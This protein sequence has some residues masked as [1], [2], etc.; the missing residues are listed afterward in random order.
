[1]HGSG[2]VLQKLMVAWENANHSGDNYAMTV[3]AAKLLPLIT[4]GEVI[5][6][7]ALGILINASLAHDQIYKSYGRKTEALF[8]GFKSEADLEFILCYL[9]HRAA[10]EYYESYRDRV[11]NAS[12]AFDILRGNDRSLGWN[13]MVITTR[14]G[15]K[16]KR[17][18][19]CLQS[20][21]GEEGK[22]FQDLLFDLTS[23]VQKGIDRERRAG[24]LKGILMGL[25]SAVVILIIIL[26]YR[27]CGG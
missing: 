15:E 16:Q 14:P 12:E 2:E 19:S 18:L 13:G 6:D 21:S 11:I 5:N 3:L 4:A 27:S 10:Q 1:M 26:I 20:I 23:K 25:V 17:V 24:I 8:D 22:Y 7:A 9:Y